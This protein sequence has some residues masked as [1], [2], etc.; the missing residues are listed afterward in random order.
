LEIIARRLERFAMHVVAL[1]GKARSRAVT[2]P[3]DLLEE[4]C[5]LGLQAGCIVL[6]MPSAR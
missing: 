6:M 3:R 4:A 1:R 2:L 5:S